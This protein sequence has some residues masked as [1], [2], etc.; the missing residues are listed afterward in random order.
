MN[1]KIE[2]QHE[3]IARASKL[4]WE[5]FRAELLQQATNEFIEVSWDVNYDESGHDM[6]LSADVS[7]VNKDD[8]LL[9][10]WLKDQ[11]SGNWIPEI[12]PWVSSVVE[13]TQDQHVTAAHIG[14]FDSKWQTDDVG[15]TYYAVL[16]GYLCHGGE[17]KS[18][19]FE[20]TFV[21]PG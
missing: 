12:L 1:I 9:Q 4:G 5:S 11:H 8:G 19:A 7:L 17:I 14:L 2:E 15:E 3:Q 20:K 21:Y 6:V 16:W 13:F 10:V 18:F